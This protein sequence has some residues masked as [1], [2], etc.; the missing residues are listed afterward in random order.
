MHYVIT[1][2]GEAP[3]V[4]PDKASVWYFV[5]NSDNLLE[6]DHEKIVN[7]A[8]G[9]A[10]ATGTE[11]ARVRVLTA[12]H[13]R[14]LN[15]AAAELFQS[16][17]ELVGMPKWTEEEQAFARALQKELGEKEV[18]FPAK[19]KEIEKPGATLGGGSS[20]VG[21]VSLIAPMATIRIPGQVPGVINHH[22]STTSSNY[23][24]AAWKGMNAGAKAMAASAIDLMTD[25]LN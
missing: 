5:R 20:D 1:E 12:I 23:G 21:E 2:G 16:N 17:I 10:L 3:N 8:K 24:S 22:W 25:P 19:V 9:A 18:G 11:L 7:A 14:Y 4:V 6:K 15:K 13:Q